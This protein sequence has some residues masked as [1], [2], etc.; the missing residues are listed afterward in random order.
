M[1]GFQNGEQVAV[2]IEATVRA[3]LQPEP[4]QRAGEAMRVQTAPRAPLPLQH[5]HAQA[6]GGG[7]VR[8]AQA[9][10]A[11]ADDQQ[12]ASQP[13]SPPFARRSGVGGQDHE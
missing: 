5:P 2:G 8:H 10:D 11:G 4:L 13:L 9:A 3:Q 7:V 1:A 12:I 6:G